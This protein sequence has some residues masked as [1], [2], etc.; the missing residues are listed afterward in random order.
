MVH[1]K[2]FFGKRSAIFEISI[3]SIIETRKNYHQ[4]QKTHSFGQFKYGGSNCYVEGSEK[5][6]FSNF[7]LANIFMI[8]Q[9]SR[10]GDCYSFRHMFWILYVYW[11]Y[12]IIHKIIWKDSRSNEKLKMISTVWYSFIMYQHPTMSRISNDRTWWHLSNG[13]PFNLM[14]FLFLQKFQLY[15]VFGFFNEPNFFWA[16][17]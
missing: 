9:S 16:N 7:I 13:I 10:L 3:A 17:F 5:S 8:F 11:R 1:K 2:Y 6:F 14:E 4:L 15:L 12:L